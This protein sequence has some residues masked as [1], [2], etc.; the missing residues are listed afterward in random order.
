MIKSI[1]LHNF[2]SHKDTRL[3][4]HKGV[5]VVVGN[6]AT[7]KTAILR[8]LKWVMFNKPKGDSFRSHW[9]GDMAV[10][11]AVDNGIVARTKSKTTNGYSL[12]GESYKAF[13]QGVPDE[14]TTALNMDSVNVQYQFDTHFLLSNSPGEVAQYLNRIVGLD[15]IDRGMSNIASKSRKIEQELSYAKKMLEEDE[16]RL[17]GFDYLA[18]AEKDIDQLEKLQEEQQNL[19][20]K[21]T[22]LFL[23]I[24]EVEIV[25]NNLVDIPDLEKAFDNVERIA[26]LEEKWK[27]ATDKQDDLIQLLNNITVTRKLFEGISDL[28]PA[29]DKI[30]GLLVIENGL[31]K[32]EKEYTDLDELL[33]VIVEEND[34]LENICKKLAEVSANYQK[35]KPKECPLCGALT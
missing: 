33:A 34:N 15:A 26:R 10:D 20:N 19:L 32:A 23:L 1:G 16:E 35:L 11:L 31:E 22:K 2:Q 18:E 12:N 24:G 6:S 7:G 4:F 5:N 17:T 29:S 28:I 13:G 21:K 27:M 14:I 3:E 30:D 8:A 9:G 25:E